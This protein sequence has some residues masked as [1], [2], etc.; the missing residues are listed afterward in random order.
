MTKAERC[1]S[2]CIRGSP[3]T[4][5]KERMQVACE[6]E[7]GRGGGGKGLPGVQPVEE[8]SC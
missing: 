4:A 5:S 3:T 7:G 8:M 1:T 2:D 6:V